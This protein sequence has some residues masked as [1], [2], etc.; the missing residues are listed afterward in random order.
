MNDVPVS[1]QNLKW[2]R[3]QM[4]MAC[5]MSQSVE[6]LRKKG[7]SDPAILDAFEAVRP[8]GNALA[9]GS[10]PPPLIRRMPKNLH[11]VDNPNL[12][13]YTLDDFLSPKE[14]ARLVALIDHHLQPSTLILCLR[15][16]GISHQPDVLSVSPEKS[17]GGAHRRED[18]QDTGHSRGIFRGHPGAAL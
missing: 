17:G 13:L 10:R 18:L 11:R 1:D 12:E 5:D 16:Q 9:D 7:Y 6:T 14:C 4:L 2:L 8:R 3:E 15:R